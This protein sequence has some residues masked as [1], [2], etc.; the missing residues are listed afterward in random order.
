MIFIEKFGAGTKS[1]TRDP[2]ITSQM[3]YQLSYT[4][5]NAVHIIYARCVCQQ[6][7][8]GLVNFLAVLVCRS[9]RKAGQF[10]RSRLNYWYLIQTK[11]RWLC[12]VCRYGEVVPLR[13]GVTRNM[14]VQCIPQPAHKLYGPQSKEVCLDN[15]CTGSRNNKETV[16]LTTPFRRNKGEYLTGTLAKDTAAFFLTSCSCIRNEAYVIT[17]LRNGERI[18]VIR[19]GPQFPRKL[20][21]LVIKLRERG[22]WV[23]QSQRRANSRVKTFC[24]Q[25]ELFHQDFNRLYRVNTHNCPALNSLP[26]SS[27][28]RHRTF[29]SHRNESALC[30]LLLDH[31]RQI[32]RYVAEGIFYSGLHPAKT[33]KCKEADVP[34]VQDESVFCSFCH[35]KTCFDSKQVS[36]CLTQGQSTDGGESSAEAFLHNQ[37]LHQPDCFF[38]NYPD[39]T[40]VQVKDAEGC[41]TKTQMF[42]LYNPAQESESVNDAFS[43]KVCSYARVFVVDTGQSV[44]PL[45]ISHEEVDDI[46]H[47]QHEKDVAWLREEVNVASEALGNI[48]EIL[49]TL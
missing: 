22:I 45:F 6:L 46:I 29:E 26:N 37:E 7:C 18:Y 13:A 42:F 21:N 32:R 15:S 33:R 11:R 49:R 34:L 44:N 1:R 48:K 4:G 24:Q 8:S 43:Y 41:N 19:D 35:R 30:R 27:E 2:L 47:L 12:C 31:P 3:L 25:Q 14:I 39:D 23:V 10:S 20:T 16:V 9:T 17:P 28:D 38:R 5:G 40:L 36:D